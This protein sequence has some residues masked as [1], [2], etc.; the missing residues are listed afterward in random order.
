[1]KRILQSITE[2]KSISA[3][4][5]SNK[6]GASRGYVNSVKHKLEDQVLF[7]LLAMYPDLNPYWLITGQGPKTVDLTGNS[8][9]AKIG[10]AMSDYKILYDQL[11]SMYDDIVKDNRH[12][13]SNVK[14][15][16]KQNESLIERLNSLN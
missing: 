1:M 4:Q 3:S 15:L 2:M 7:K 9:M 12:L 10:S 8:K 5:L 11:R 14:A 16:M 6:L 13:E